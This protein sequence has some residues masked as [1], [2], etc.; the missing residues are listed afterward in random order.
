VNDEDRC[1]QQAT[2]KLVREH[3]GPGIEESGAVLYN[4]WS[5][6]RRGAIYIMGLNPGGEAESH[7]GHSIKR[8]LELRRSDWCAYEDECW[9]EQSKKGATPH[10][11]RVRELATLF[12]VN[13]RD[14]FAVNAIFFRSKD[15][16]GLGSSWPQKWDRCWPVHQWFLSTVRPSVIIC[17]GN[18]AGPRPSAFN[19][20]RRQ[21]A[22]HKHTGVSECGNGFRD[23]RWFEASLP[24]DDG[25]RFLVLGIPHPSR[26]PLTD[27]LKKFIASGMDEK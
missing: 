7:A 22:L 10:Q 23:G 16:N 4:G 19:L 9:N 17:L 15:A 21:G 20:L 6:L 11:T 25:P 12:H 8:S 13:I 24:A 18:G 5:T 27:Q 14:A 3:L 26:F 2:V 1:L